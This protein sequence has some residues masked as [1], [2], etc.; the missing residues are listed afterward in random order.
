MTCEPAIFFAWNHQSLPFANLKVSS[1]FWKL[2]LPTY[3]S[4]PSDD[5]KWS[6]LLTILIFFD[7]VWWR[8]IYPDSINSSLTC[9]RSSSDTAMSSDEATDSRCAISARVSFICTLS[10][11]KVRFSLLYLLKYFTEFS[12][13]VS[14]GSRGIMISSLV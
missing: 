11:S 14:V 4:K 5:M 10:A 9:A 3:M 2:F 8:C 1:S 6:G 12:R 13:G 7:G